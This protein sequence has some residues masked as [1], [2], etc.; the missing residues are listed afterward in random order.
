MGRLNGCLLQSSLRLGGI[1]K[2]SKCEHNIED[3][4]KS[5]TRCNKCRA[6]ISLK[7]IDGITTLVF[8]KYEEK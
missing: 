1:I 4:N 7:L 2:M 6:K 8:E 5:K 3:W